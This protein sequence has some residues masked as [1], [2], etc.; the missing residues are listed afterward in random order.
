MSDIS[1]V[2]RGKVTNGVVVLE[3]GAALPDGTDVTVTPAVTPGVL[4]FTPEE[5]AEFDAW[6]QL[7]AEAFKMIEDL[8]RQERDAAG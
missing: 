1:V 2:L 6:D 7:S 3:P 8:E 5:Q 4:P